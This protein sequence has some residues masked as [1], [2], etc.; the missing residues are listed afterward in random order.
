MDVKATLKPSSVRRTRQLLEEPGQS[1]GSSTSVQPPVAPTE[2][3]KYHH[4]QADDAQPVPLT[5]Q[6]D[7]CPVQVHV[8]IYDI[9]KL[10][11]DAIVNAATGN[12]HHGA[13]VAAAIA[14]AAGRKLETDCNEYMKTRGNQAISVGDNYISTA[15]NLPCRCVIHAVGPMMRSHG[16]NRDMNDVRKELKNTFLGCLNDAHMGRYQSLALPAISS[17]M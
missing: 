2:R 7:H 1:G 8:L 16:K 12:L 4:E 5:F 10:H 3:S 13:G 6:S 17:G 15:G 11:V 9:T 14:K